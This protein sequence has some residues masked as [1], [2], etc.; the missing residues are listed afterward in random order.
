M[1]IIREQRPPL[2]GKRAKKQTQK[3]QDVKRK[4]DQNTAPKY[5]N[6]IKLISPI[7]FMTRY[8]FII[9]EYHGRIRLKN[10]LKMQKIQI[11]QNC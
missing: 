5:E 6:L 4:N 3:I 8:P 9:L 1:L 11:S 10:C 2:V 7:H